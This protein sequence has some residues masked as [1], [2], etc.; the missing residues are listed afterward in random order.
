MGNATPDAQPLR[1]FDYCDH[2]SELVGQWCYTDTAR[3][4]RERDGTDW[5]E[6]DP[7][8]VMP[9]Y[10]LPRIIANAKT[11]V[12]LCACEADADALETIGLC[13]SVL[14]A[15]AS[16]AWCAWFE[17]RRVVIVTHSAGD[18]LTD[19][20]RALSTIAASVRMLKLDTTPAEAVAAGADK[21]SM[22]ALCKSA[23]EFGAPVAHTLT[24]DEVATLDALTVTDETGHL[25]THAQ[26]I[27]AG[28]PGGEFIKLW[29]AQSMEQIEA[30]YA[31]ELMDRTEAM[32]SATHGHDWQEPEQYSTDEPETETLQSRAPFVCLGYNSGHYYYLPH[33]TQQVVE[34][35]TG[36]QTSPSQLLAIAPLEFWESAAPTKN[37]VDWLM[38][39]NMCMR[40]SERRGVFDASAVRGRGAWFDAGRSVLHLGNRLLV[41]HVATALH[42]INSRYIYERKS[43]I[44]TDDIAAPL[45][46]DDAPALYEITQA[47]NWQRQVDALLF[48]GW[49]ALAPI[50]GALTW[51]PHIWL[52]G[53]RGAGKSWA[54]I[55]VVGPALGVG[56]LHVQSAT[57]EAG[58]RQQLGQ[59]ARPVVFDEAEGE[60][61]K[62][63]DRMQGVLELAR[64]SS[65]DGLAEIAKGSAGGKAVSYRVRSM[66]LL[67]SINVGLSQASDKSRFTVLSLRQ[68]DKG[69]AGRQQFERLEKLVSNTLTASWC[70][71]LR[72]RTYSLI[73][74]IRA[75]AAVLAKAAAE[76]IGNQRAGDQLGALLAGAYS[77]RSDDRISLDA[78]RKWVAS[79]DWI[80]N[81]DAVEDSDEYQLCA[82]IMH[83]Q[84]RVDTSNGVKT[85]SVAELVDAVDPGRYDAEVSTSEA[86]GALARSGIKTAGGKVLISDSHPELRRLLGNTA[87]GGNWASVLAR[88]KGAERVGSSRFAGVKHRA[89]SVPID[90]MLGA[91]D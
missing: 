77:L 31:A 72:S 56:A 81:P 22:V 62:H 83:A 52:T 44:E 36:G 90:E 1:A 61:A 15:V 67:G 40:W 60:R 20:A 7:P 45:S 39:G 42:E 38:A 46:A 71:S 86:T 27:H 17:G 51:R 2:N 29:E 21:A 28:N 47:M 64:Q 8:P 16:P 70:A 6:C 26:W 53:Q 25:W 82:E 80:D 48:A 33:R 75:N 32:R 35:G 9:P 54:L 30:D 74:I 19:E 12:L 68:A 73:P 5:R 76:H 14:P 85:R 57:S 24:A 65:S 41:D 18:H 66:F 55:N 88:V 87:W 89:V 78:A 49:L 34:I 58:I 13:A 43:Q 63:R 79:H 59:D 50:S 69:A 4:W 23:P 84:I 91:V 3:Y 37:G 10:Q 11:S